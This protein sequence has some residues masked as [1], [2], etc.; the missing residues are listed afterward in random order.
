MLK[1]GEKT[2]NSRKVQRTN[3]KNLVGSDQQMQRLEET[4]RRNTDRT[5]GVMFY[6][7]QYFVRQDL[8]SSSFPENLNRTVS[9][10]KFSLKF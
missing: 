8:I 10:S 6:I 4:E 1:L 3:Q 5:D 9:I 7:F 2:L